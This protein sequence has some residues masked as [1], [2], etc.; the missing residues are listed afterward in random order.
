MYIYICHLNRAGLGLA[1][2]CG[3][4]RGKNIHRKSSWTGNPHNTRK[5]NRLFIFHSDFHSEDMESLLNLGEAL[6]ESFVEF[7]SQTEDP[8]L[9]TLSFEAWMN[10]LRQCDERIGEIAKNPSVVTSGGNDICKESMDALSK[11]TWLMLGSA[12]AMLMLV[13]EGRCDGNVLELSAHIVFRTGC[14]VHSVNYDDRMTT[15]DHCSFLRGSVLVMFML[16]ERLLRQG[17]STT[18][19]DECL[20]TLCPPLMTYFHRNLPVLKM[21]RDKSKSGMFE[22]LRKNQSGIEMIREFLLQAVEETIL[23]AWVE[24]ATNNDEGISTKPVITYAQRVKFTGLCNNCELVQWAT[25]EAATTCL[26]PSKFTQAGALLEM[27]SWTGLV[28]TEQGI[29]PCDTLHQLKIPH[30]I[31]QGGIPDD[32]P[33]LDGERIVLCYVG[34]FY[35]QFEGKRFPL[36]ELEASKVGDPLT[37]AE[38]NELQLKIQGATNEEVE[39]ALKHTIHRGADDE[40]IQQAILRLSMASESVDPTKEPADS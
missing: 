12:V 4:S 20:H 18:E 33:T 40:S 6:C 5:G 1:R 10:C 30:R 8:N 32:I 16:R 14:L 25:S 23:F 2:V 19:V 7:D 35:R 9:E 15:E 24:E 34:C 29:F 17:S 39:R 38:L 36:I 26:D 11:L 13:L 3:F 22:A 28:D 31:Y 27:S 21:W 37:D